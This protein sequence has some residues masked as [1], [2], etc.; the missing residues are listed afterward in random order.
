[1][2]EDRAHPIENRNL[3]ELHGVNLRGDDLARQTEAG[4][5]AA[6]AA[7]FKTNSATMAFGDG[8]HEGQAKPRSAGL[9]AARGFEAH[10]RFEDAGAVLVWNARAVIVDHDLI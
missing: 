5:E 1:M 9:G 6:A 3:A 8:F 4:P 2:G 7:I 10:E